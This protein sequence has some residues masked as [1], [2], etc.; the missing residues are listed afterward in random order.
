MTGDAIVKIVV[1][2]IRLG[3]V[4][5]HFQHMFGNK[6]VATPATRL[7]RYAAESAAH[8]HQPHAPAQ[9]TSS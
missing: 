1:L 5:K 3:G 9:V 2:N 8:L 7:F 4:C 6:G